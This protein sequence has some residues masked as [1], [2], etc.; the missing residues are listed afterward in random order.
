M[1]PQDTN[2]GMATA[3]L[4]NIPTYNAFISHMSTPRYP[5]VQER[6]KGTR[7][8]LDRWGNRTDKLCKRDTKELREYDGEQLESRPVEPSGSFSKPDRI[9]HQ[10]PVHD[11]AD[12]RVGDFGQELRDSEHFGRVESAV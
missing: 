11:R 9:N 6:E 10:N 12:D 7:T 2:N 8:H 1:T 3:E 4:N 5:R